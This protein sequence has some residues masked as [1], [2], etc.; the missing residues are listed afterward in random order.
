MR[1]HSR[2]RSAAVAAV[3]AVAAA[4]CLAALGACEGSDSHV[5]GPRGASAFGNYMAIGTGLSM[6]VQSGGVIYESQLQAWPAL[7]AHA[8]VPGSQFVVS[9][10]IVNHVTA[11]RLPLLRTPGCQPPLVAP[12]SV[13]VD[14]AGV[15]IAAADST[16]AGTTDTTT[17][18]T[19]NVALAGASAWAAVNLT[20]RTVINALT[21]FSA[22]DRARYPLVLGATQ[23]QVT[24]M[25]VRVPTFV[26]VEF[27]LSE[28]LGA[29]TT[30]LL[31]AA[32][33]YDQ[34]APYTYVPA[35]VFAPLFAA[36]ADSVVLTNAK[37]VLL[38]VP[39]VSALYA[40]RPAS[41]LAADSTEL[42]TFGITVNAN[43]SASPNFVFTG[44]L[45]PALAAHF[46]A[47]GTMQALSCADVPGTADGILTPADIATL[48]G[49]VDGMNAQIQQLAQQNGWAFADLTSVY[50][51]PVSTRT[52]YAAADQLTCLYPYGS[53][54]SLDGVF[55]SAQGQAAIAAAVAGAIDAK[56]GFTIAIDTPSLTGITAPK[57]CP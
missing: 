22:A 52:P 8:A 35:A 15:S 33:S 40:L 46:A 50:P 47:T 7:L 18:P 30:G 56:Y 27:G 20:P 53:L 57:L 10:T 44:T 29:A 48:D 17:P 42:A 26:S 23:S 24:A 5:D 39:K 45:V 37:V 19:N 43:C 4:A 28:V 38:S 34:S 2:F 16:C 6:G 25:R 36:I 51:P 3:A 14:L 54:V 21:G 11:F 12:L 1:S 55:P 13:A 9:D 31:V 32:T 49:V 41:E